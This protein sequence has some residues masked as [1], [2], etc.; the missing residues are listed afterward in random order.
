[1]RKYQERA[2]VGIEICLSEFSL[3][4]LRD[5]Q[6]PSARWAPAW[7]VAASLGMVPRR[8]GLPQPW[9]GLGAEVCA[10][11]GRVLVIC[12]W[13]KCC[14]CWNIFYCGCMLGMSWG[15]LRHLLGGRSEGSSAVWV[16]EQPSLLCTA[17][18]GLHGDKLCIWVRSCL[19]VL[20]PENFLG[21]S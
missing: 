16:W 20:F 2:V 12:I 21:S 1:M 10:G 19:S 13:A 7:P 18:F 8:A 3:W 15:L 5:M 11:A 6:P 4:E 9:P 17:A 14:D